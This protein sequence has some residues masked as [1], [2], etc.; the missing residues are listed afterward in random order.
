MTYDTSIFWDW[1]Q[2]NAEQLTMLSEHDQAVQDK[3]L[4]EMQRQLDKYCP[5]LSFEITEP[6]NDG[7]RVVFTAEGDTELF[8]PLLKL[9]DEAPDIDWW[10]FVPFKQP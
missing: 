9:T 1:F 3:L 2:Q 10:E 7:R 4:D 8:E 6:N 5:G